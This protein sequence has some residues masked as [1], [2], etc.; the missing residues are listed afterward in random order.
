LLLSE[1]GAQSVRDMKQ[2]PIRNPKQ[3]VARAE[4]GEEIGSVIDFILDLSNGRILFAVITPAE[5]HGKVASVLLLP[6]SLVEVDSTGGIFNFRIAAN[7]VR[8][9]PCLSEQKW[10]EP[11]TS[12]WLTTVERYWNTHGAQP[13]LLP[14]R[15]DASLG[16][17]TALIGLRVQGGADNIW[18]G[19]IRELVFDP[20][21]GAIALVVL[22]QSADSSELSNVR[23]ISIPWEH[24]YV[25]PWGNTLI[26]VAGRKVLT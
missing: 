8:N 9:A 3:G 26:A 7:T 5:S 18:V 17:A 19:T 22:A 6:W 12:Q 11:P 2:S 20:N 4:S 10:K 1:A 16:K 14:S 25:E 21:D 15:S 13:A 23:F 24:L